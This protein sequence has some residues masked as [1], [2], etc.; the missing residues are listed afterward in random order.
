MA[1]LMPL[2]QSSQPGNYILFLFYNTFDTFTVFMFDD[3]YLQKNIQSLCYPGHAAPPTS[4]HLLYQVC[5]V[6][7]LIYGWW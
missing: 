1:A 4:S 5:C 6:L 3:H 2:P 7:M